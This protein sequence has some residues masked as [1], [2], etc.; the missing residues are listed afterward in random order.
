MCASSPPT[1]PTPAPVPPALPSLLVGMQGKAP[2]DA[3]PTEDEAQLEADEEFAR[4]LQAKMDAQER[5]R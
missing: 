5:Q 1:C 2:I 4:Q 3:E